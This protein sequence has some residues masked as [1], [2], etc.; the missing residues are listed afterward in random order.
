MNSE[1]M[2]ALPPFE[3]DENLPE[4]EED[5]DPELDTAED[6]LMSLQHDP[7]EVIRN[8]D[9][10]Q[11]EKEP[12]VQYFRKF[13]SMS[14]TTDSKL[15]ITLGTVN[16]VIMN[17]MI[18]SGYTGFLMMKADS[19][20]RANVQFSNKSNSKRVQV[21]DGSLFSLKTGNQVTLAIDS[22]NCTTYPEVMPDL[23]GNFDGVVGLQWL[24]ALESAIK[25]E[26]W[27]FSFTDGRCGGTHKKT[28]KYIEICASKT[29]PAIIEA[30]RFT[31]KFMYANMVLKSLQQDDDID[32]D[33]V[34]LCLV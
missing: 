11:L 8:C 12:E 25:P 18:D 31:E 6:I 15:I 27:F 13:Y 9:V 30:P 26:T 21:G 2:N 23:K 5:L 7:F 3:T 16:G 10:Q 4:L 33:K 34:K 24:K 1:V 20:A 17:L 22:F 19:A 29:S 14:K 32:M 28:G